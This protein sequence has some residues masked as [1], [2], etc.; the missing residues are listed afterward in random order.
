MDCE[1]VAPVFRSTI[2]GLNKN[3]GLVK[4]KDGQQRRALCPLS[5]AE[6]NE[7]P[8]KSKDTD[9]NKD[10]SKDVAPG[11]LKPVAN[12]P[13]CQPKLSKPPTQGPSA[14][15]AIYCDESFESI[16]DQDGLLTDDD[17]NDDLNDTHDDHFNVVTA[18]DPSLKEILDT[19][20][21]VL[22][23]LD[24]PV[25]SADVS[26]EKS[27]ATDDSSVPMDEVTYSHQDYS[28]SILEYMIRFE[29]K[30]LPNPDYMARQPEI[31]C[32]MRSILIDWMVEVTDEYKMNDETLFLAIT[33]IDRYLS[34]TLIERQTFQLLGTSCLFIAAKYEEIYPP[35]VHEF[36]Y[37][38][39]DSYT[40]SQVL[41]ME[42][43]ILK[44]S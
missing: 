38:T 7:L 35:D 16:Q 1:N 26:M 24:S 33:Y 23:D 9:L 13:Q 22:P 14:N 40:K 27:H 41:Q 29:K 4:G 19:S 39:D 15:F 34:T 30:F 42:M 18:Q 37:V 12:N 10:D 6:L 2:H 44:V 20:N 31:N 25:M 21:L 28:E 43:K 8:L 36:V 3:N 17:D 11:I 5:Q 32:K